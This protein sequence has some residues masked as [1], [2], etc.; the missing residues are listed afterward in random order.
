MWLNAGTLDGARILAPE[1]VREA[2]RDQIAP[3]EV[4]ADEI[5]HAGIDP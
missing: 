3:L 5:R 2:M 1:T 4:A